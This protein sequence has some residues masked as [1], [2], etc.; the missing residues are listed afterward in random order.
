MEEH[1]W[2]GYQPK[3]LFLDED[4]NYSVKTLTEEESV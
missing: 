4:N 1:E 2:K 3:I